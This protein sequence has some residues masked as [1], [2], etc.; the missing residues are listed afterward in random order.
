MR[1]LLDTHIWVW[2][3]LEPER[4]GRRVA[5]ILSQAETEVW[6][7]PIS[8]W[9]IINLCERGRLA[10]QPDPLAWVRRTREVA[11][12]REAPVTHEVTLAMSQ[13]VLPHRDPA[14]RFLAAT[15]RVYELTLLTADEYLLNGTGYSVLA[16][17]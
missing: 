4:I 8:V 17:R 11:P 9:E 15:A 12:V 13:V 2:S 7:S 14:D 16:N 10:L 1:L 6:V 3:H 5:R